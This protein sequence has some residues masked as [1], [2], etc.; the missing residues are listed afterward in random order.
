MNIII[1]RK[2]IL[3]LQ[4]WIEATV[5]NND[6]HC[7]Y[8]TK[9]KNNLKISVKEYQKLYQKYNYTKNENHAPHRKDILTFE[10]KKL[11]LKNALRYFPKTHIKYWL[12]NFIVN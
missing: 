2:D 10:E 12:K 6:K 3:Y 4:Y 5:V 11:A 1:Q 9:W 8:K 7:P